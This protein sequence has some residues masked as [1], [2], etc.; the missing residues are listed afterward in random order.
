MPAIDLEVYNGNTNDTL[1]FYGQKQLFRASVGPFL[2]VDCLYEAVPPP[3]TRAYMMFQSAFFSQL[4]STT[5]IPTIATMSA[6]VPPAWV[7]HTYFGGDPMCTSNVG[8]S[9]VQ[10]SFDFFDD[11]A[12]LGR[13]QVALTANSVLFAM[14]A[15]PTASAAS[16]CALSTPVQDC[17]DVVSATAPLR[18]LLK[19]PLVAMDEFK[20]AA[21]M[22]RAADI[23]LMQF[24]E[25]SAGAWT[26]LRQPLVDASA[27]SFFGWLF[28]FDW[29]TGS[30]EV[31][32]FQGDNGSVTLISNAHLPQLY[33]TGTEPL[34][35]AT[36]IVFYLIASTSVLLVFVGVLAI[37]YA[38]LVRCNFRGRNLFFFNRVVAGGWMGRPLAALRG[39]TAILLLSTANSSLETSYGYAHFKAAPR[40]W[41]TSVIVTGEATW[42]TYVLNELLL[43][44]TQDVA[45]D[46]SPV[47][48]CMAWALLLGVDRLCPIMITGTLDR[49]C[50]GQDMDFGLECVSGVVA[51][52]SFQRAW[53][54]A[55]LQVGVVACVVVA[56]V[57]RR[58]RSMLAGTTDALLVSGVSQAFLTKAT[59]PSGDVDVLD[60][61]ACVLSGLLPLWYRNEAYTFDLKLWLIVKDNLS[62]SAHLKSLA[63]PILTPKE[64][65]MRMLISYTTLPQQSKL[66]SA[67]ASL[68]TASMLQ[69]A[70]RAKL[71]YLWHLVGL[72][73]IVLA[74]VNSLMYFEVT[75]VSWTNDLF[76]VSFNITGTHA[77][78][79]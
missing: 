44:V 74:I 49:H 19:L 2:S 30:R 70:Q 65:T 50:V 28:L 54:L 41:A 77:F 13:L 69:I 33:P 22:V 6:P 47:S 37:V 58:N 53:T 26:L 64:P 3:L 55:A 18:S 21:T 42:L 62:T 31:V 60:H 32:S 15:S 73:S 46:C 17:L 68:K 7:G 43:I 57:A 16:V 11:C 78:I 40:S 79:A 48:S 75:Q 29:V 38:G 35:T 39:A 20:N 63:R 9:F 36:Q 12:K 72:S 76:W 61:V 71:R 27:F 51:I 59:A 10:Q 1:Y 45:K 5:S 8:T 67:F 23:G 66:R 34:E 4:A 24:A 25:T 56:C 14:V 52:G